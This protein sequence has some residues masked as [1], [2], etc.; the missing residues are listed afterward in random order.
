MFFCV[1]DFDDD[2]RATPCLVQLLSFHRSFA[3]A[4]RTE[5]KFV[6]IRNELD[7]LVF[8]VWRWVLHA[9]AGY[10]FK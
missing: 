6:P 10:L 2:R 5:T 8:P 9:F 3:R 1:D 4:S 7:R